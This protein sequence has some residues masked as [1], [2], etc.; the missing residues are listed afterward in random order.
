MRT[1]TRRATSQDVS[2]RRPKRSRIFGDATRGRVVC[3][4]PFL[5]VVV[6]L[7]GVQLA[8]SGDDNRIRMKSRS[9][10]PVP[11]VTQA[12]EVL[13]SSGTSEAHLLIQFEE[14]PDVQ[15]RA[16]L[17]QAGVRLLEYIPSKTYVATIPSS[18]RPGNPALGSG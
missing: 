10:E 1:R 5:F 9:F 7:S 3:L 18:L 6:T 15:R 13:R 2:Q 16:S 4:I 8:S 14:L 17:E 12:L 11:D